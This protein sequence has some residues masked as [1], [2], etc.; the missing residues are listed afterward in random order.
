MVLR[1]LHS[2]FWMPSTDFYSLVHTGI[3]VHESTWKIFPVNFG[4]NPMVGQTKTHPAD[5]GFRRHFPEIGLPS[6]IFPE[7]GRKVQLSTVVS[8]LLYAFGELLFT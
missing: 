5:K 6:E 1:V 2:S 7:S 4:R 8:G 3:P